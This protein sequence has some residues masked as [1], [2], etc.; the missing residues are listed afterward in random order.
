MIKGWGTLIV[1][2]DQKLF[3]S[4]TL[5]KVYDPVKGKLELEW[6]DVVLVTVNGML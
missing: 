4:T 2:A 3:A 6:L 1:E 5:V